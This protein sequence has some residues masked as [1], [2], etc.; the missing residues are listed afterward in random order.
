M[1]LVAPPSVH[2]EIESERAKLRELYVQ[3]KGEHDG[4]SRAL[5]KV[6]EQELGIE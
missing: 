3:K 2:S 1:S 4:V 6:I 5:T